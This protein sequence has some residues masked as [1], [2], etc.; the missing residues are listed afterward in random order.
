[1]TLRYWR[2]VWHPHAMSRDDRADHR[3]MASAH[4]LLTANARRPDDRAVGVGIRVTGRHREHAISGAQPKRDPQRR[5]GSAALEVKISSDY[6][7]SERR[8]RWPLSLEGCIATRTAV[9]ANGRWF[10][11]AAALTEGMF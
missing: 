8:V 11:E 9:V 4:G 2:W 5:G 6:H 1:M 10:E 3:L 7:S